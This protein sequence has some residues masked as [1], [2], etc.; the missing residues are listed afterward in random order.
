MVKVVPEYVTNP[1]LRCAGVGHSTAA[2][3]AR[4]IPVMYDIAIHIYSARIPYIR[5]GAANFN[6][7]SGD[8]I[9]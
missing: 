2:C 8:H 5:E 7:Y 6:V 9:S 4:T 3:S 1:L